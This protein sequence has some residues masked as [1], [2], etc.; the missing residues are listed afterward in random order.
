[1]DRQNVEVVSLIDSLGTHKFF[2]NERD[3][4]L[5]QL[6]IRRGLLPL[7]SR[8][9]L[10]SLLAACVDIYFGY[11]SLKTTALSYISASKLFFS[12][13]LKVKDGGRTAS[14]QH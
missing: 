12:S 1:M 4:S 13:D 10:V 8:A 11:P 2:I 14:F 5:T 3:Q 7:S 6:S 9:I